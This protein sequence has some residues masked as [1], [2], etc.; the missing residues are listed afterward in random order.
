MAKTRKSGLGA[1]GSAPNAF[2]GTGPMGPQPQPQIQPTTP[3]GPSLDDTQQIPDIADQAP[4]QNNTPVQL[5]AVEALT[6]MT[7]DELAALAIAAKHVSMPNHLADIKDV[8]QQFVYAAGVNEKPL[9]LDAKAYTQFMIDNNIKPT[10]Q[11]SRSISS[12]Q[13]TSGSVYYNLTDTMINNM[14]KYSAL[15]YIGGKVGGQALGAGAYF[16]QIGARNTGYGSATMTAVLNPATARVITE[17][18]LG[19]AAVRFAKTHPKFAR[20]I[21]GYDASYKSGT[22]NQAVW[23]LVLGYNVIKENYGTY[24][25][26]IDRKALVIKA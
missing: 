16:D 4:D 23:A 10:E 2:G 9:V 3:Q 25:N 8:T 19:T 1:G 6:K 12:A 20:A 13:Y 22:N 18:A 5:D 7:D 26:V 11:L 17:S 15:T 21:G 24:H 14:Y